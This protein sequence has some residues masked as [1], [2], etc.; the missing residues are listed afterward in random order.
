ME[1]FGGTEILRLEQ[2]LAHAK[3]LAQ[4]YQTAGIE[5]TKFLEETENALKKI[6]KFGATIDCEAVARECLDRIQ[7]QKNK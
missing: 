5:L 1:F 4:R 7:I 6:A 3:D 2:E